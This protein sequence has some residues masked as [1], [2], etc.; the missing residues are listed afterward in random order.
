MQ[1]LTYIY[2]L[3][4]GA[5]NSEEVGHK[6]AGT[7]GKILMES[8]GAGLQVQAGTSAAETEGG[9]AR[10]GAAAGG[11]RGKKAQRDWAGWPVTGRQA[12]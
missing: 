12:P 9:R 10:A 6:G 1:N 7:W 4:E 11:G 2:G 5:G 3:G 8:G